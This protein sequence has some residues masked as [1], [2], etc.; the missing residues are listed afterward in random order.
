[1]A[2]ATEPAASRPAT[3][4]AEPTKKAP[5]TS[6]SIKKA[7]TKNAATKK[8]PTKRA[9]T[10]RA[11][12]KKAPAKS[13][14]PAS[15]PDAVLL[16]NAPTRTHNNDNATGTGAGTDRRTGGAIAR[17]GLLSMLALVALGL[18]RV[19]HG[20]LVNRNTDNATYALVGTLITT[21]TTA[22]L[23]LPGG[24]ASAASKFIPYQLARDNPDGAQAVYD[25]LRRLGYA[26]GIG[27]GLVVA[28]G[29]RALLHPSTPEV[30][31]AGLLTL[32]FA[33]YSV[34]KAALYGFARV[35]MYV[36]LEL[37]G[38]GLALAMTVLVVAVGSRAYLVPL[39]LGY[40]VLAAGAWWSLRRP[41]RWALRRLTI[42]GVSLPVPAPSTTHA[43]VRVPAADRRE[44]AGY[45]ALASIGGLAG[46]GF[47][48]LL[49]LLAG[50]VTDAVQVSYFVASVTLVAPLYFLPR[51]LS[52]AL[53]PALAHAHGAGDQD[54][55]RTHTDVSTRALVVLLA[56]VFV[57]GILAAPAILALFGGAKYASGTAALQ[58]LEVA[59]Y[60]AVVQVA[61]TNSLSSGTQRQ[62]RIPVIAT[63][64]GS[65][66]GLIA[67]VPLGRQLGAAGVSIADLIAVAVGA[68]GPIFVVWRAQRMN[69]LS[70][71]LRSLLVLFG[72]WALGAMMNGWTGGRSD[73]IMVNLG[74]A[75]VG[76]GAAMLV[77]LPEIRTI[78][79]EGRPKS[80]VDP[81]QVGTLVA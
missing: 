7:P 30:I 26:T 29:T 48:Q 1:V 8:A 52:L 50:R 22:G 17:A 37:S 53:F 59:T 55:V 41:G 25:M 58:A 14:A 73:R 34:E 44:I 2:E 12:A 75:V 69:W 49:P 31:A 5:T 28:F 67:V 54:A 4:P 72:A 74:V 57:V 60:F 79:R 42:G 16:E 76:G 71:V 20:I 68:A 32:A 6:A 21:A 47:L 27:L 45:V 19:I 18:T 35:P 43:R 33:V 62:V 10:K 13:A 36:R 40:T 66:L 24:L 51:A 15:V 23:F 63:V 61:A 3:V 11:P 46:F 56:P 70:P 77:L 64:I 81:A 9:P 39:M 80:R 38:S 65:L 78:V